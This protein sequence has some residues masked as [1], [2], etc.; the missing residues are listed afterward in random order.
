MKI[1]H[2]MFSVYKILNYGICITNRLL[3]V[4][5]YPGDHK[6]CFCDVKFP[7]LCVVNVSVLNL[8]YILGF[9]RCFRAI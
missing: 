2:E 7:I 8:I 5:A 4:A 9:C 1:L 3:I 6:D